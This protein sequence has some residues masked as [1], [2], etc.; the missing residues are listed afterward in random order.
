MGVLLEREELLAALEG[1]RGE[2][3]RLVFVGGEAGVGKSSLLRAF[4]AAHEDVLWGACD[5][6]TTPPPLGPLLDVA[7]RVG[8]ELEALVED[9]AEARLVGRAL[10][11]ALERPRVLVLEDVHWADEATLDVVRVLGRRVGATPSLVV[12]TY[13]DDEVDAAHPLRSVLGALATEPAVQRLCVPPLSLDAVR[14]LAAETGADAVALHQRTGG[15]SFYVTEVLAA[16]GSSLPATVADA[17]LARAAALPPEA[18]RLLDAVAL[19]PGSAELWLLEAAVPAELD[20]LAACL[21]SGMLEERQGAVAFRHEL[22]RLALEG[23][24]DARRRRILHA[25]IAEGL[26]SPPGGGPD[27]A[28]LAHHAEAAGDAGAAVAHSL[29]AAR[30]AAAHGAHRQAA[31]QYGRAL[32]LGTGLQREER[33]EILAAYANEAHVTGRLDDAVAAGGEAVELLLELG[34]RRAAG[35]SLS[36]L[37]S[38]YV[39]LGRNDDAEEASRRAVELLEPL[40]ETPELATAYGMQAFIRMIVR[41]NY[42]A[43]EWGERAAALAE[44]FGD[45]DGVSYA[46]NMIGTSYVMAGETE[47]GVEFLLRS[48]DVARAHGLEVRESNVYW[49]LGSGLAEMYE[50]ELGERYLRTYV[51]FAAEHELDSVYMRAWLAVV[52]VYRGRWDEAV[53]I[54]QGVLAVAAGAIAPTTALIALG[55]VRARR[56]DPGADAALRQALELAGPGGH[57]QRLGHVHAARAEAAWL[58]GDREAA[59][60]EARAVYGLALEKRHLWFA[61]ELAYWQWKAGVLDE[62]PDWIAEPYRLQLAG[63]AIAAAAAWR[64]RG[65]PYEAARALAESD[66][67]EPLREALGIFEELGAAPAAKLVRARLKAVGAPVPRGPRPSTRQNPAALTAREV[68]VLRL[69]ADGLRNADVAER[70]VV[71]TRT[72]DH[73]VGSILRKLGARNRGEAAAAAARLGLL[74]DR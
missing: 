73:H 39:G 66:D 69:V 54:A 53:E 11:S 12:A 67:E 71:S 36:R 20:G 56:G 46:L 17:V 13:R 58:A 14:A 38:A 42:E 22:A 25:A 4:A 6:L 8:G 32:R 43:V 45:Q 65:C 19:V 74:E 41:D 61:G 57:L 29:A 1:A 40:G 52:H 3:G 21:A 70:L 51:E 7:P 27:D 31:D 68:E 55:R 72:V 30:R 63:D 18:R 9:G 34:D 10:L 48:L 44:R 23:A 59:V 49:M 37:T 35:R 26:R 15:N 47:R 64:A 2:G 33:A 5:G 28:R 60:A 62:A 24:V 16:G 50:F